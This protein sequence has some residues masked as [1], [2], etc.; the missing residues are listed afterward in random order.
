MT[1]IRRTLLATLLLSI[2]PSQVFADEGMWTFDKP[3]LELLKS[4]HSFEPSAEWLEHLQRSA[5]R[6]RSGG[7]SMGNTLRR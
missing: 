3:P 4:R 5:V 6:S 2:V 1:V 7:T